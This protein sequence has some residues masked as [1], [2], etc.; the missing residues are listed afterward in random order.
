MV[1]AEVVVAL[2]VLA[3]AAMT[4]LEPVR[5]SLGMPPPRA[6]NPPTGDAPA[7]GGAGL[8]DLLP[9]MPDGGRMPLG[10]RM[11]AGPPPPPPG[12]PA[13]DAVAGP[14][15]GKVPLVAWPSVW[16]AQDA[17]ASISTATAVAIAP[18]RQRAVPGFTSTA[19]AV[20]ATRTSTGFSH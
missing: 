4:S 18:E 14:P 10:R 6:A 15:A 5:P 7:A 1:P 2:H 16:T 8:A 13:N 12:P 19:V 3:T 11:P 20:T 17:G 9:P